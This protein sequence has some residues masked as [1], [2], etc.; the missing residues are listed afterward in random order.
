MKFNPK[1][2]DWFD[3]TEPGCMDEWYNYWYDDSLNHHCESGPARPGTCC[4][5]QT[6]DGRCIYRLDKVPCPSRIINP[7]PHTKPPKNGV[8]KLKGA[9]LS[10]LAAADLGEQI[11]EPSSQGKARSTP[12]KN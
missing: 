8:G 3:P 2:P 7:I 12:T 5:G 6:Q 1:Y 9:I 10:T 11:T 4:S